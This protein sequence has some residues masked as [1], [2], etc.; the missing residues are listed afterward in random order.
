MAMFSK[1][2][3]YIQ[4]IKT[5]IGFMG[6]GKDILIYYPQMAFAGGLGIGKVGDLATTWR[7]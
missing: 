4:N 2:S 6:K 7:Q 1:F 3:Q 5:R